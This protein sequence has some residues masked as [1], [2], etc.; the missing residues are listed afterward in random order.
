[1][2]ADAVESSPS[3]K[4]RTR[5]LKTDRQVLVRSWEEGSPHKE[6]REGTDELRQHGKQ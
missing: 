1:M 4:L 2:D 5:R 6:I 3:T